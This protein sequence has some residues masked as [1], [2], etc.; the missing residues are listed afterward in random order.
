MNLN[1]ANEGLKK[2]QPNCDSKKKLL[3]RNS[4]SKKA[5]IAL[6]EIQVVS[7]WGTGIKIIYCIKCQEHQG[8]NTAFIT[9]IYSYIS[10]VALNGFA[11]V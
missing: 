2:Y 4:V 7:A 8:A 5:V 1:F 6:L 10:V 3:N 11:H 9:S